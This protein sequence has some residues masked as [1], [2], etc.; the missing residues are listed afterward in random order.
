[1]AVALSVAAVA[2]LV[3]VVLVLV[4][5]AVMSLLLL[6]LLLPS[7]PAV[8]VHVLVPLLPPSPA[9]NIPQKHGFML[10]R[11]GTEGNRPLVPLPPSFRIV[12]SYLYFLLCRHLVIC[13]RDYSL[14][15]SASSPFC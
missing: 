12:P 1:M 7:L 10:A 15:G 4:A 8:L 2:V 6:L 9:R 5:V 14:H 3:A 13:A 11:I